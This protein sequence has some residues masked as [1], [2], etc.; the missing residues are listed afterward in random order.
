[1]ADI[2]VAQPIRIVDL[3][4]G[5]EADVSAGGNLSVDVKASI[6]LTVDTELPAAAALADAAAN[7]T[8]PTVGAANLVWN[9]A[10]W[11]RVKQVVAAQDTTGTG[12][13][14]AGI[15]AQ[16]DDASTAAVTE[17]QFAPVRISTRR[18]LLV[19]GV[20]SGTNL[21]VNLAASAATV[22]VDTELPAAAAL[23][24][25][26]ANPTTPTVGAAA[27]LY[28]GATWDRMRGDT[29]NGLDVDVTRVTGTVTVDTE[30]PAAAALADATANPTVPGVGGFMLGY[31]GA[32]WDRVRTA[33][34]GRL[35]VDVV[36]GGG[37]D[38]PTNPVAS[39]VTSA[40]LAAGASANLDTADI[41]SKFGW[42]VDLTASV[43]IKAV[44]QTVANAI[45]TTV[46]TLFARAGEPIQWRAPNRNFWKVAGATAGLDGLRA[47]ITNLD[48]SE[49]ADVYAT[50]YTADN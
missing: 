22:T 35:Q 41:P 26:A 28:N 46:T 29:T 32:T 17:N 21:N 50:F 42:G 30:L 2:R 47:V 1:M 15:L 6:T 43:P 44:L 10:T 39:V 48:T 20:A 38:T 34:T 5:N 13:P 8:T 24:D 37:L 31:N 16:F 19:E 18:A 3:D 36:T 40:A 7:P 49:A 27:L 9:G 14:A 45:A 33:N 4:S 11:D 23:A 12:I 25:A